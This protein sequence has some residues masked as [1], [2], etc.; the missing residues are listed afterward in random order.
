MNTNSEINTLREIYSEM[1]TEGKE[2]MMTAATELLSVQNNLEGTLNQNEARKLRKHR[3]TS[4]L[5]QNSG[6]FKHRRQLLGYLL[7]GLLLLVITYIFWITL[8]NPAL[9]MIEATP[10]TMIWIMATALCG[11][12]CIGTGL[13][14]FIS[15][16]LTL[17]WAIFAIGAGILCLDPRAL[18]DFI[19]IIFAALILIMQIIQGKQEKAATA[20]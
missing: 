14:R 4:I 16:K 11:I 18:T 9:R 17:S 15:R 7:T 1:S 2:K 19:G 20:D 5:K 3:F 12:F 6:F 10:L 8:I 13:V